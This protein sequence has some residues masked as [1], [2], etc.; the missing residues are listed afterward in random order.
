MDRHLP[1][2]GRR[3]ACGVLIEKSPPRQRHLLNEICEDCNDKQRLFLCPIRAV[4]N[5]AQYVAQMPHFRAKYL[6]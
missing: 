2:L 5:V 1:G 4:Q 3:L 6:K